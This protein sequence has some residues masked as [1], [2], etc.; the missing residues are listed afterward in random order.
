MV[1]GV[2][3]QHGQPQIG[4]E[5]LGHRPDDR[6]PAAARQSPS[7][8]GA[9]ATSAAWSSSITSTSGEL[10]EH[11]GQLSGAA[12]VPGRAGRALRSRHEHDRPAAPLPMRR[13]SASGR[14]PDS[15]SAHRLRVQV[16]RRE[17]V[18]Q[19]RVAGILDRDPVTGPQPGAEDPLDAVQRAADDRQVGRIDAVGREPVRGEFRPAAARR[20]SPR[21]AAARPDCARLA[22]QRRQ[23]GQQRRIR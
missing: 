12:G 11:R 18:E 6:P 15:S 16:H 10:A 23:R 1:T 13:A 2:A 5:R 20:A 8:P 7:A 3:C 4:T 17:Q 19:R 14:T 21:R 9:P 22:P